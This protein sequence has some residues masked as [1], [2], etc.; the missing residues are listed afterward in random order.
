MAHEIFVDTAFWVG[1]FYSRDQ[2]HEESQSTW[3]AIVRSAW[4]TCTTNWVLHETLTLL[5]CRLN[6]HDLAIRALSSISRWSHIARVEATQLEERTLEIFQHHPDYR[7]SVVDCA[8]FACIE[9]RQSE[10][11]LSYDR[12][13]QQAQPEFNFRLFSP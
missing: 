7:W 8:N 13:F 9:Q 11:A 6:R 3:S 5:S 4:P 12:N 2:H 10:F 1:L